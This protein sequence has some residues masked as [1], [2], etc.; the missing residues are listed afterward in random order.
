MLYE[1]IFFLG[2]Q[3][4]P[5]GDIFPNE[6]SQPVLQGT[7]GCAQVKTCQLSEMPASA[8]LWAECPS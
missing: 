3:D 2:E 7:P 1:T 6:E 5:I 4:L 8:R